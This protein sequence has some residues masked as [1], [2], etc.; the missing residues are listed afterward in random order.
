MIF[1]SL[2]YLL[3]IAKLYIM[4]KKLFS[5]LFLLILTLGYGWHI[6]AQDVPE[7]MYFKFD[8]SVSNETANEANPVTRLGN[9]NATILGTLTVGGTGQ[10]NAGLQGDAYTSTS[11]HVNAGWTGTYT[12]SWTISLYLDIT[13]NGSNG[14]QYVFGSLSSSS[15][16]CF[17]GG[18]AYE[19]LLLRGTG[20]A[21]VTIPDVIYGPIVAT[22]TYDATTNTMK[23]Y[24]DGVLV[25]TL[26]SWVSPTL[27]GTDFM[28]GGYS[29]NSG[30]KGIMDEFRFYN[31]VLDD[32]E[33]GDTWDQTLPLTAC[34]GQPSLGLINGVTEICPSVPFSIAATGTNASGFVYQWQESEPNQNNWVDIPGAITSALSFPSGLDDP[35]DFR[36]IATCTN[37]NLSDTSA[38]HSVDILPVNQ[39]YCEPIY[40]SGDYTSAFS[41]S[42]AVENVSFV[43]GST[44]NYQNLSGTD[45]IA[46]LV[47]E[48]VDFSHT[49][50]GGS[51]TVVIWVDWNQNGVFEPSEVV[52]QTYSS[53][54]T[55]LGS[56]DIPLTVAPGNYRLRLRSRFSTTVPGPCTSETYGS[57]LDYTLRVIE[58]ESCATIATP[59]DWVLNVNKD[60][61]CVEEDIN[62]SIS[63]FILA[64]D[65]T[66]QFQKSTNGTTW[67]NVGTANIT[68]EVTATGV[69]EDTYFRVVWNCDG[70]PRDSSDVVFVP[71][72]DPEI[73]DTEDGMTC[74]DGTVD[75]YAEGAPGTSVV[76]YDSPTPTGLPIHEGNNFTTPFLTATTSY[77]AAAQVGQPVA[78]SLEALNVGGNS[79]SGGAMFDIIP[80]VALNIDS[81]DVLA[82]GTGSTVKIYYR[83]GSYVGFGENAGAWTLHETHNISYGAGIVNVPFDNPLPLQAN[84]TYGIYVAYYASYT[85]GTGGNQNF[86]NADMTING[87]LGLCSEFGGVNDPRIFN[88]TVHYS[89]TGCESDLVE[90]I[91]AV[92]DP[93]DLDMEDTIRACY[94][95]VV[96]LDPG[97][98]FI[99]YEWSTGAT[100]QAIDV[101]T[102]GA[103]TVWVTGPTGCI[104]SKTVM[105]EFYEIPVVDLGEDQYHC[106]G[107]SIVL[108]AG[109]F[110]SGTEYLWNTGAATQTITVTNTGIYSVEV[111]NVV[112]VGTDEIEV[113]FEDAATGFAID[114]FDLG[115]GLF[116]FFVVSPVN[117]SSYIWDFG[118]GSPTST[119]ESP[120]HQYD[121]EGMYWVTVALASNG[122]G[123]GDTLE[124]DVIVRSVNIDEF[125]KGEQIQLYPNPANDYV[126]IDLSEGLSMTQLTI[127]DASGRVIST[128]QFK[129]TKSS[130]RLNIE[131]LA[132]GIYNVVIHTEYGSFVRK[133]EVLK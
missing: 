60:T 100:T 76:W 85:N 30:V 82:A 25:Q 130:H 112:C 37:S 92:H 74:G 5:R 77:W 52:S 72:I 90:V 129:E 99:D 109:S 66:Y 33:I 11:N 96:S 58:L 38:A 65:V 51:N 20:I 68:G 121:A 103:Y 75:L 118:D 110:M 49:Y 91:A 57:A 93:I 79:C 133:L 89:S 53:A 64:S 2:E 125:V 104:E 40:T 88:G 22:F 35:M 115:N 119:D 123:A 17:T 41:T 55:Q 4:I 6:A 101:S 24:K 48:E 61:I 13:E 39:C 29:S 19:N 67:T 18:V 127:Q 114:N 113:V 128:E 12:G 69:N 56:F 59:N 86:S 80:N 73:I 63:S 54:A 124:R 34:S 23:A 36:V 126:M 45:T 106:E 32:V 44:Y 8:S 47:G 10:F 9:A 116:Q 78:G 95:D 111:T 21:D 46:Q 16:R 105:V 70:T 62:L 31:R 14:T 15:F 87:G 102:P 81:L 122:C 28:V 97:P 94:G 83:E 98:D 132:A 42:N 107:D 43:S 120:Q 26:T 27:Q 131:H 50:V 108:N 117:I 3:N 1:L 71:V 84:T 7:L